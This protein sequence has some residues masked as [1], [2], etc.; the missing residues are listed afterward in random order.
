MSRILVISSCTGKKKEEPA[1]KL[2]LD[3]FR[4]PE[5]LARRELEL[6]RYMLPAMEMYEGQ[7]HKNLRRGVGLLRQEFDQDFVSVAIVSAGYGLIPESR[8]IA[9]YEVTFNSMGL[10]EAR[11]WA[12]R[13]EIPEDVRRLIKGH[14]L[15]IL[16]L[17]GRYLDVIDPP[18]VPEPP[19]RLVFLAKPSFFP[20]L[21]QPGVTA[22]PA[23]KT[24]ATRWGAGLVAL[25]GRMFLL[26]A[27]GLARM[28]ES[29]LDEVMEDDT[30]LTLNV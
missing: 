13:L 14:L 3:D 21:V 2:T 8:L 27:L 19:Q 28:G 11:A 12:G 23:G 15:V 17:G 25:K 9:P 22:V 24:E 30:K 4:D 29:V 16:L 20:T 6:R 10:V 18:L 5:R 26:F 1:N 7:Q